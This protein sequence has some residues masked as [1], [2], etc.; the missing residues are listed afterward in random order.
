MAI[1]SL[2]GT[3]IDQNNKSV[4]NVRVRAYDEDFG[5]DDYL[6]EATTD[7]K[8]DFTIEFDESKFRDIWDTINTDPEVY[9]TIVDRN[10]REKPVTR[11]EPTKKEIEYHIKLDDH[12]PDP[13]AV[14]IYAGNLQRIMG[15]LGG[16]NEMIGR[17][18][19]INLDSI[20]RG[21]FASDFVNR[22]RQ[23]LAGNEERANNINSFMAI[24]DGLLTSQ[25]E[26]RNLGTIGYDGPQVPRLPRR[27]VYYQA[28]IWPRKE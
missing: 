20:S 15:M 9:L 23:F 27:E 12:K 3:L 17:E 25:L 14:D 24:L 1:F 22:I 8:G 19:R 7:S 5:R 26:E 16:V 6:G 28:I 11:I 18:Y 21:N 4:K 10:G 13:D 2:E